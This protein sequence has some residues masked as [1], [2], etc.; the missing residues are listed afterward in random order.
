MAGTKIG[1]IKAKEANL[2]KYGKDFYKNI[3]RK[4]GRIKTTG[5]F[6]Q[7]EPGKDGLTGPER[8]R[9]VGDKGGVV[10]KRGYKFIKIAEKGFAY[11]E[12]KNTGKFFKLA[13][14]N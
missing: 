6:A 10:G 3:G 9:A 12:Q 14:N 11:Y 7:L 8:A 1:G 13:I 4:G 5:G 2:A